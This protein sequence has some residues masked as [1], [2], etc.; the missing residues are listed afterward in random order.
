MKRDEIERYTASV[1]DP[2]TREI[3]DWEVREYFL[4]L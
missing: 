3:T 2:T 1:D 4:D